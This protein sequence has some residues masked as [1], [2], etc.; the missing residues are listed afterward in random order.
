[1]VKAV[2]L[3]IKLHLKHGITETNDYV[4]GVPSTTAEKKWVQ[5]GPA[6]RQFAKDSGAHYHH[7]VRATKLRMHVA[8][9]AIRFNL[10]DNE[11]EDLSKFMGHTKAIHL[12]NY[13]QPVG[14]TDILKVSRWLEMSLGIKRIDETKLDLDPCLIVEDPK[15]QDVVADDCKE[16]CSQEEKEESNLVETDATQRKKIN[17]IFTNLVY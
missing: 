14:T 5:A 8:L 10:S 2:E 3:I 1:M 17:P 9:M 15:F 12:T 6:L 4:F 11:V 13:R 7:L 16:A